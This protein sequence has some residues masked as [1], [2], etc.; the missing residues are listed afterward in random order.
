[1]D[2]SNRMTPLQKERIKMQLWAMMHEG[3]GRSGQAFQFL[4]VILILLSVAMLPL[5]YMVENPNYS[6]MLLG[7]EVVITSLF[8]VEYI[9]RIYCAPK[10][11]R[12]V[13]SSF[14]IIDLLSILPFYVGLFNSTL[15]KSLRALR[16]IRLIRLGEVPSTGAKT[17][18]GAVDEAGHGLLQQNE[19][20][21][22]VVSHHPLYLIYGCIAPLFCIA[23]GILVM[24]GF[25]LHPVSVTVAVTLFIFAIILLW[26]TWLN[27]S[28]DLIYVTDNRLMFHDQHLFGRAINQLNYHAITN[29]KPSYTGILSYMFGYGRLIVETAADQMG[30]FEFHMA[31]KHE[32]AAHIIMGKC[33]VQNSGSLL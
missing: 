22:W 4:L 23:F 17:M 30:H 3:Y 10:R 12:Y 25:T 21:L 27:Y 1:M 5:E 6:R 32:K 28:Y 9:L 20:V 24:V 16:L 14:G 33:S 11:I 19:R 2:M 15:F 31:R 18:P 13:F 29:V 7:F 8:T 26:R